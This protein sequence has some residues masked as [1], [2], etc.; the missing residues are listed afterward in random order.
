M[1]VPYH[2]LGIGPVL[3][4]RSLALHARRPYTT[5][6][7]L[8][9]DGLYFDKLMHPVVAAAVAQLGF[10]LPREKSMQPDKLYERYR[11][12]Q[13]YID[14]TDDDARQVCALGPIVKQHFAPLIDDFYAAI[15]KNPTTTKVI[16]GGNQ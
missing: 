4:T 3:S 16:T 6:V 11:E 13:R 15:Q 8:A 9:R 2:E 12:L 10:S 5:F 1:H 7:I 14:W